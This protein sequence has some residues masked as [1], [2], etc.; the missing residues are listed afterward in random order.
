MLFRRIL[1]TLA[2]ALLLIAA[3]AGAGFLWF[4]NAP[5]RTP[6][7]QPALSRLDAA[8]LSAFR[9]A[10]NALYDETRVLV[11]LSPT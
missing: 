5:R 1:L 4:K 6:A 7:G 11:L 8:T 10:F 2:T 3:A 9:D